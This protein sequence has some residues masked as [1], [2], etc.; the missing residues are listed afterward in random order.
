MLFLLP[1]FG[2]LAGI[3]LLDTS[4]S[5]SLS[6]HD[7]SNT[8]RWTV[9]KYTAEMIMQPPWRGW[10]MGM[11][12][13]EFQRFMASLPQ[14]P[15]HEIMGH[16]HNEVLYQWFEGGVVALAGGLCCVNISLITLM[17]SL[18]KDCRR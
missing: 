6:E 3:L 7:G 5:A 17:P 1:L 15:S 9:L 14:N 16:P 2:G 4:L 12:K 8:Q 13:G 18:K 10:G 11:F